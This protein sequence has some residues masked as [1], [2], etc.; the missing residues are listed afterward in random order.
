MTT[1]KPVLS[2]NPLDLNTPLV[3]QV[4]ENNFDEEMFFIEK[5]LSD[6]EAWEANIDNE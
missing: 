6:E 3:Q 1:N 4:N 5:A 2:K